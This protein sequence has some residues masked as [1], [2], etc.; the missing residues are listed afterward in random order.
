MATHSSVLA[1]RI[2]GTRAWWAAVYGVAQGR[3][4]LKWLSSSSSSS[5]VRH[6]IQEVKTPSRCWVERQSVSGII[7]NMQEGW[8]SDTSVKVQSAPDAGAGRWSSVLCLLCTKSQRLF[9]TRIWWLQRAQ[10]WSHKFSEMML[11][12]CVDFVKHQ[13]PG[14]PSLSLCSPSSWEPSVGWHLLGTCRTVLFYFTIFHL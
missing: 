2:P 7:L 12:S 4:W 3:T 11:S 10:I 13:G 1:W 6:Q 5:M 8:S 14:F 9:I